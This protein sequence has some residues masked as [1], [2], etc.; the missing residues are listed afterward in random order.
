ML[1]IVSKRHNKRF[2]VKGNNRAEDTAPGSVI[3]TKIV[4]ADVKE[5][6]MQSHARLK[7]RFLL[8]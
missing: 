3:D 1:V 4:R 2:W 8:P 5:F 6:Y 7:V